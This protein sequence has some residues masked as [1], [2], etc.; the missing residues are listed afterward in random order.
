MVCLPPHSTNYLQPLD[1]CLF[2]TLKLFVWAQSH[3]GHKVSR[4]QFAVLLKEAWQKSA[5]QANDHSGF[6]TCGTYPYNPEKIPEQAF[7]ISDAV[8]SGSASE[9]NGTDKYQDAERGSS[10][11]TE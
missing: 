4:A 9:T 10:S 7:S 8:L 6:E 3:P 5:S 1:R 2:K 11:G